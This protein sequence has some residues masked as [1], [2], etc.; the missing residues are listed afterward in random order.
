MIQNEHKCNICGAR[1]DNEQDLQKHH[2][3]MHT[4]HQCDA[5]GRTFESENA[6]RNHYWI[7]HPEDTPVR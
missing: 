6:L 4:V 5:C 3:T 1:F 7:F 2:R